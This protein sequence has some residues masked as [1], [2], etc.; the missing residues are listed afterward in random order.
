MTTRDPWTD[1][2][3][4]GDFAAAWAIAAE[5]L[6]R[7]D[8]ATR[9]DPR[10]PYHLRWVWDGSPFAGRDVLV[11]CY[12][13]LGDTLMFS[14]F[15]P[16]LARRA[17]RVTVEMQPHLVPLFQAFPGID[18]L[19]PFDVARPLPPQDCDIEIMELP[20]ALRACPSNAPLPALDVT[21]PA[22]LPPGTVALCWAAGEW[23]AR[24]S[25]PEAMFAPFC[26]GPALSLM[27]GPTALPVLNPDGC[28]LDILQTA[29]LVAGSALVVTVDT[30]IAHLAG[31]LQRPVW[32]LA[33]HDP[34]WRWPTEATSTP[35][36][37]TMH[38]WRQS[39]R[40][41]WTSVI[42]R[43]GAALDR[44]LRVQTTESG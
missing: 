4:C 18:R 26:T 37:P 3:R 39:T 20:L 36:Y 33:Q 40:G 22:R 38:V 6:A 12:H 31:I 19:V 13:G 1:A 17:A 25:V 11:R 30:M 32:L 8:P 10:L 7:R 14:R 23:D 29:Q 35:W 2:M 15:L 42:H 44:L 27:P 5:E 28:P 16:L 24:R 43:V 21:A 34:D 41:D 9:D